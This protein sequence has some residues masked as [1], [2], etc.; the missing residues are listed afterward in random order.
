ALPL[1]RSSHASRPHIVA[2]ASLV[3]SA[4]FPRSEAYGASKA[5]LQY[6][7]DSLRHDLVA[8]NIDVTVVNPGFIDTPLTQKNN[9]DMPFLMDVD[10]AANRII[11]NIASR[12]RVYSFPKRLQ[13]LLLIS[14]LLPRVWQKMVSPKEVIYDKNNILAASTKQDKKK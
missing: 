4:P 7:F 13:G 3:T 5:A 10:Q 9:F 14:K 12:P 6:F 1:L 2:I 11:K 8:D